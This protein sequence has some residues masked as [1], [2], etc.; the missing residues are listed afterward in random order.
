MNE[1][2]LKCGNVMVNGKEFHATKT[3]IASNLVNIS[4]IVIPNKFKHIDKGSKY[5][6]GYTD[7]NIIRH[8]CIILPQLSGYI[9]YFD[10]DGK[11]ISFKIED[12]NILLKHNEIWNKTKNMLYMKF[13]GQPI[14]DE[15]YIKTKV[16][17]LIV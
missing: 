2:T 13:H 3:P 15:K 4:R 10:N 16:K 11:N 12:D 14:F 9:K 8:L 6:T 1:K 5:F 7:D 17:T